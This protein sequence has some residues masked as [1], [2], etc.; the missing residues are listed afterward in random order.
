MK[1][2]HNT[3]DMLIVDHR[4]VLLTVVLGVFVLI[5]VGVAFDGLRTGRYGLVALMI[6]LTFAMYYMLKIASTRVRLTFDRAANQLTIRQKSTKG[7]QVWEHP[8]NTIGRARVNV[9]QGETDT[10]RLEIDFTSGMD[11]GYSH[12]VTTTFS[13]D[14]GVRNAADAINT[15]LETQQ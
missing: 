12:P 8:L 7:V 2:T 14:P 6:F 5:Y 9:Q 3:P 10:Y 4:P 1:V 11:A 15:W 13:S